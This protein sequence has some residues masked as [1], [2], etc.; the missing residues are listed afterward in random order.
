MLPQNI[1]DFHMHLNAISCILRE[2]LPQNIMIKRKVILDNLQLFSTVS[3]Q[4]PKAAVVALVN[5]KSI[6]MRCSMSPQFT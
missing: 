3:D 2:V 6:R 4:F 1:F 5:I